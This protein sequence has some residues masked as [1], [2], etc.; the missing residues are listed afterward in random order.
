MRHVWQLLFHFNDKRNPIMENLRKHFI[1][2][3]LLLLEFISLPSML[4]AQTQETSIGGIKGKVEL[5]NSTQLIRRERGTRYRT[6]AT[7]ME[8]H[9]SVAQRNEYDNIVVYLEGKEL[10]VELQS[11]K[12]AAMD[13]R[14]AEFIPHVLAIQRGTAV[15]FINQDVTF[16]NV[17][18]LS[19]TRKFNI[20]RR[21]TGEAVPVKFDKPGV[22]QVFCD[23]HSNMSAYI[24]VLE[25]PFFTRPDD[26]GYFNISNIPAGTYTLKVWHEQLKTQD[27]TVIINPSST[28]SINIVLE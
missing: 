28:A 8:M 4:P 14:N 10:T 2:L 12:T 1:G 24:I 3:I 5:R 27:Q 7:S 11:S 17:F 23:I 20:G 21:P 15:E 19:T 18:S 25:N 6:G 13:Q 26:S 9:S 22:V 16:H